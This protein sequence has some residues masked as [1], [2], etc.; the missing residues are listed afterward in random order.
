MGVGRGVSPGS[1]PLIKVGECDPRS[2]KTKE[3]FKL[4]RLSVSVAVVETFKP[5]TKRPDPIRRVFI[6]GETHEITLY[7]H[8]GRDIP[9][10]R[11]SRRRIALLT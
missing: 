8:E 6:N 4:K 2:S 10:K 7:V 9:E 3:F 5:T 1:S 11:G